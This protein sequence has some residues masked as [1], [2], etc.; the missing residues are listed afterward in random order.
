MARIGYRLQVTDGRTYIR[1]DRETCQLEYYFRFIGLPFIMIYFH[2]I[3]QIRFYWEPG[4]AYA[5]YKESFLI[6]KTHLLKLHFWKTFTSVWSKKSH[7]FCKLGIH[8]RF[9]MRPVYRPGGTILKLP[10]QFNLFYLTRTIFLNITNILM[11][12]WRE[13][14]KTKC[15]K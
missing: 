13:L 14:I 12:V 7:S 2:V 11:G 1:M 15:M 6:D 8:E 9:D 4:M 5:T 10:G 3:I